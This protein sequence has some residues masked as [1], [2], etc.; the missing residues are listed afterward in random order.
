MQEGDPQPPEAPAGRRRMEVH[1]VVFGVS[2]A[3]V[4][5][6]S[7]Y[8]SLATDN[9]AL[10]FSAVQAWVVDTFGWFYVLSVALFLVFAV[11][12]AV[13]RF[14]DVKLGPD[15]AEPDFGYRGWFAMLFSAGMGIGLMFFG[16]AEP[17]IHFG[18]PPGDTAVGGTVE[19]AREAMRVTF[20][21]WGIH[22]WAIYI[23]V[24]LA[25]AYFA[26]RHNLPLTIRS[27]LYPVIGERIHGPIGDAVDVFAVIGTLF[28]VAT[29]LGFGALQVN[30]GLNYLFGV[31][32]SAGV[33]L[34]LIAVITAL[35]TLS[36]VAGLDAGIRRLSELNLV[37][38]VAL[39]TF[40][41]VA[42]PTVF[43]LQAYLQNTGSYLSE[44]VDLTFRQFAW[45]PTDWMGSWTLFY[46]GWWI[47]WAPFVGMF[48][49]RISRGR[50]IRE[51]VVGVIAV[52]SLFTFLWMTV[53]GDT[54][55]RAVLQ[56][57][58]TEL[59]VLVDENVPLALFAFLEQLPFSTLTSLVATVLVV[60]FFVTSSDS[61]SLVIDMITS[62]GA[63]DPPVWQRVFW[64]VTQG[65]VAAVLLLAGGLGA[66]QTAA[67]ASGLPFAA[68]ML[69]ICLG[70]LTALRREHEGRA[71]LQ[72][73][74]LPVALGGHDWRKR[75][76]HLVR[77]HDHGT[78]QRFLGT[79]VAPALGKVAEELGRHG[80]E[81]TVEREPD[82][83]TLRI[84]EATGDGFVYGVRLRS[85]R[86]VTFAFVETP[87]QEARSR[88]WYA[89][90]WCSATGESYDVLGLAQEQ[91]IDDLL[92]HYS[93]WVA[94]RTHPLASPRGAA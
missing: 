41:L 21:H 37:L 29:S 51:F 34:V 88:H 59:L 13:S 33:Q 72:Q 68:V 71:R 44:I 2:A 48:I 60:T 77:R 49:A 38:A 42:G 54:A 81:A 23:V 87:A 84:E 1:P 26:F 52:P 91:L 46:W 50:T 22:A 17:L 18:A 78:A 39:L 85:Y 24:G 73:P 43:L 57:Q 61:G 12:L 80:V 47:A 15:D 56:G 70:L 27:A 86:T 5:G 10:V 58:A 4:L 92:A 35:A 36:V 66:L 31:E 28:G 16:V 32:V 14:G 53:F 40:V 55:I 93:R 30:A 63:E 8:G 25:L 20:L 19:A 79:V 7:L 83:V 67:I 11:A 82:A 64:A 65:V 74:A 45:E 3:L 62:G 69:V 75:L 90:A 76:G 6:F 9:A 94:A 89:E